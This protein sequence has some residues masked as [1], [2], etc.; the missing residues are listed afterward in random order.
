M[1]KKVLEI[2]L[3]EFRASG[4]SVMVW[5]WYENFDLSNLDVDFF[6]WIKPEDFYTNIISNNGGT[7]YFIKPYN[8]KPMRIIMRAKLLHKIVKEN[9]YDYIHIHKN[10]A[11]TVLGIYLISK[12]YARIIAHSHNT[13]IRKSVTGKILHIICKYLSTNCKMSRIACSDDAAKWLYPPCILK[14]HQYEVIKYGIDVQRFLYNELVRDQIR[15]E[16]DLDNKFVIGHIGRFVYQKN[17]SFLIDIFQKVHQMCSNAVLLLIGDRDEGEDLTMDIKNKVKALQ[18]TDNVIFYGNSNKV[19]EL[20]QAMDCFVLPSRFEGLGIVLIEAQ[21]A[22]LK[23]LCSDT[24]PREAK[25]TENLKYMSLNSPPERWAEE[26]LSYN[27]HYERKNTLRQIEEAGYGLKS[28]A[29][30]IENLYFS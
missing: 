22:G 30:R 3:G 6:C 26:L 15:S 11:K 23:I 17:H 27:D 16:L 1:S 25:V 14:N 9:H 8:N 7:C 4:S 28:S 29:R 18:L 13:N 24:V 10:N 19:N 12:K 5:K 20:Y 21:A 2:V